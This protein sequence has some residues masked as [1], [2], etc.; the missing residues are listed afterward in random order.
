VQRLEREMER[1]DAREAALHARMA[2]HATD[3]ERLRELTA[4]GAA[5]AADR[6][7][8]EA[9]WLAAAELLEA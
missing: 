3:H 7:R 4:E 2:E 8:A 6:E 5:I 9:A 1:L